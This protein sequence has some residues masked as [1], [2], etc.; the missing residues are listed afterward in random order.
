M[1][2][3]VVV[4]RFSNYY[5]HGYYRFLVSPTLVLETGLLLFGD[6]L[7]PFERPYPRLDRYI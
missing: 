1:Q 5:D 6:A 3:R 7:V 2:E 4:G